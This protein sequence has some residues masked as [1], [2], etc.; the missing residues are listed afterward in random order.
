MCAFVQPVV[1]DACPARSSP[2][3]SGEGQPA[4]SLF[5][6]LTCQRET[7]IMK[8]DGV[9]VLEVMIAEREVQQDEEGVTGG[10][11]VTQAAGRTR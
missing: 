8:S 11:R 10:V 9:W 3:G 4:R 6:E 7:M 2:L 5:L 1:W